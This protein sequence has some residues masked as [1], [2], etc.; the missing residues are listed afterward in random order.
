M[1]LPL[2]LLLLLV[3]LVLSKRKERRRRVFTLFVCDSKKFCFCGVQSELWNAGWCISHCWFFST[4]IP[5]FSPPVKTST[6]DTSKKKKSCLHFD[7]PSSFISRVNWNSNLGY[8]SVL[9]LLLL[10]IV[11]V[12]SIRFGIEKQVRTNNRKIARAKVKTL[13]GS[14]QVFLLFRDHQQ[15]RNKFSHRVKRLLLV[16]AVFFFIYCS[17]NGAEVVYIVYLPSC[18]LLLLS[19]SSGLGYTRHTHTAFSSFE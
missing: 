11:Q 6:N 13:F 9:L 8:V 16:C 5:S 14:H 10:F 4:R 17:I 3:I 19:S 7:C 1:C 18:C 12:F 15:Q 2:L